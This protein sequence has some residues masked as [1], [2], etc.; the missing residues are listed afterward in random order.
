MKVLVT[1]GAGY[2]GSMVTRALLTAGHQ[3]R[4]LDSLLHTGSALL[5][6]LPED[7]FE[8]V[9]GDVR[10]AGTLQAAVTGMDGVVHLAAI[11]GDPA[12]ARDPEL[13]RAVNLDA[14][15]RLFELSQSA[16]V[17]RFVFA[18]T[19]SNYGRMKDPTAYVD[20]ESELSPVSLYAE[21]KVAVEKALLAHPR[22]VNPAVTVLRLATVYG[23][24]P[25][26]RFDLTVNEF[27]MELLTKKKVV[28]FGEQFWRPYIH[29]RDVA[30]AIALVFARP[31]EMVAGQVFNVGDTRE[32]YQKGTLAELIRTEIGNGATIERVARNEDPRD[33]RVAFERIHDVLGY[34][35]TRTVP[36]GVKEIA[37][38]IDQG[39]L[40][41]LD[42]R[43]YRN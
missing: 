37:S 22:G 32:N 24:S 38:A 33:Y 23:L 18:S 15:L 21:T 11:V 25:R 14:S 19:C 13:A 3:V 7:G 41:D 28:I 12:C 8:F 40:T 9:R 1:G 43:T 2:V 17:Q 5:S 34:E 42:A 4:V 36:D 35:I 31:A 6:L 16:G 39:V 29:V 20:E 10:S 27:T 26:M 30:R